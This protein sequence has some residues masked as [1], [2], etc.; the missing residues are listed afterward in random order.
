MYTGKVVNI[1]KKAYD[2]LPKAEEYNL[3]GLKTM[4]EEALTKSLTAQTAIDILQLASTHNAQNL[5]ESCLAFIAK[6]ITEVKESLAWTTWAKEKP[7]EGTN[8][9]L[10]LEMLEYIVKSM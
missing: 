8:K 10:W 3:E 7:E 2:L 6:N 5:K 1:D 9:D 4:C